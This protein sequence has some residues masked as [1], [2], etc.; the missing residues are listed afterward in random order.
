MN[1][2]DELKPD[3]RWKAIILFGLNNATYKMAL[4]NC[5]LEFASNGETTIKWDELAYS[6]YLQY[7]ERLSENNMP[8]QTHPSRQTKLEVIIK[9]TN[10]G[11]LTEE[12]A[13][14][15]VA[16]EGFVDV[17]PRFQ[18][19]GQEK[20]PGSF[21]DYDFGKNLTLKDSTLQIAELKKAELND[22]ISARWSHLEGAFMINRDSDN[23]LANDVRETYLQNGYDRK[24]LTHNKPFLQAYQGNVC[25]YCGDDLASNIHVDHVLPRQVVNH[26]EI[27]NLVLSHDFCNTQKSDKLVARHFIDKL[28]ARNENI[29]GGNHPWKSNIERMLGTD[30]VARGKTLEKHYDQVQT[31]L[32]SNYWEGS[33]YNPETDPFY[34]RVITLLANDTKHK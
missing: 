14:E 9:Q 7:K 19:I 30:P 25:F 3:E 31:V 29:M 18:T 28:I 5:L 17:V 8:Q 22:E 12:Q 26:D 33:S 6:F 20:I 10:N 2:S 21:Y 23:Q 16:R 34:R 15:R 1:A 27:W 11:Q 4:A 13:V 24:P 32:G